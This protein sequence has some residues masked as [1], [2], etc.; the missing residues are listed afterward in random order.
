MTGGN[1]WDAKN[2]SEFKGEL[3]SE[4]GLIIRALSKNTQQSQ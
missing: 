2:N 1:I 3:R 4:F